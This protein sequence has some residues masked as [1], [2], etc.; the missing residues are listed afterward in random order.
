MSV[1]RDITEPAVFGILFAL[2]LGYRFRQW[3]QQRARRSAESESP[4]LGQAV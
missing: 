4:A 3:R 1:K 2:L